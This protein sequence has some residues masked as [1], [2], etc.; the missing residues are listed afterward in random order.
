MIRQIIGVLA[1]AALCLQSAVAAGATPY[2]IV[3]AS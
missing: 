3:T 2:K 1:A